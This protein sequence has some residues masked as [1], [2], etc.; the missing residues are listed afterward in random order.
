MS[1]FPKPH[2]Y[3]SDHEAGLIRRVAAA[4]AA[5]EGGATGGEV[6]VAATK[7]AAE[8]RQ[9][10]GACGVVRNSPWP[11]TVLSVE[12]GSLRGMAAPG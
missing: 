7:P 8:A 2:N 6:C 12:D 10:A 4:V 1:V 5:A 9:T 3:I 11:S